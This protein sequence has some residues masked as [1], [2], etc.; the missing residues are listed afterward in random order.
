MSNRTHRSGARSPRARGSTPYPGNPERHAGHRPQRLEH[1]L[2][3]RLQLLIRDDAADPALE[4]VRL[5]SLRLSIDGGHARVAYAIEAP[6]GDAARIE[7]SSRDAL[8]RAS[9]FL[10]AR[11]AELLDLK[12]TP[13]LTFTFVGVQAQ[14]VSP[15]RAGGGE[16][17]HA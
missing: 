5:V 12:R 17:W 6:P 13:T 7:R 16:P 14:G 2:L 15:E 8:G 11:L 9:R 1:I 10:R 3:E 4:G